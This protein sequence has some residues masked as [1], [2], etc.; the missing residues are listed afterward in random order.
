M[1]KSANEM[2]MPSSTFFN[3]LIDGLT[4][5]PRVGLSVIYL[6]CA[7]DELI[8]RYAQTRRR[9]PLAPDGTPL[10]IEKRLWLD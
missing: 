4:C 9:H 5:N 3:E 10:T 6:D 2:G 7:Q 1:K 8:R